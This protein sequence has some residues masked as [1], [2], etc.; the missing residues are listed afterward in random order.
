MR[1]QPDASRDIADKRRQQETHRSPR[2]FRSP[3]IRHI[4]H[5]HRHDQQRQHHARCPPAFYAAHPR[6]AH[7]AEAEEQPHT[8]AAQLVDVGTGVLL[9]IIPR[10]SRLFVRQSV[11]R[12]PKRAERELV[13]HEQG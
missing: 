9:K 7:D 3:I 8:L 12:F 11:S 13:A 5:C 10:K 1:Q 4:E 6:D 2:H